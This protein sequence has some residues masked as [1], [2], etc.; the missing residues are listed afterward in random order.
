MPHVLYKAI[1]NTMLNNLK[2]IF[3]NQRCLRFEVE[4]IRLVGT[5]YRRY[6]TFSIQ[7]ILKQVI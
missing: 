1:I 3:N 4:Y 6:G 5:G 2:Y 7:N